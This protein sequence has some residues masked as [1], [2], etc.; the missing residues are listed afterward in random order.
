MTGELRKE[1]KE[2]IENELSVKTLSDVLDKINEIELKFNKIR[3][4]LYSLCLQNLNN[5]EDAYN[6]AD[7]MS[8]KLY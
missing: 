4:L 5:I 2:L 7:E 1:I 6:I 3:D 8:G